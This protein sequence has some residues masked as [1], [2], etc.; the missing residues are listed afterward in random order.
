M[1]ASIQVELIKLKRSKIMLVMLAG[2]ALVALLFFSL[3]A[4]GA[5]LR[6]WP[7]YFFAGLTAWATFM[8]P[9]TATIIATLLAQLEHPNIAAIYG[10]EDSGDSPALVLEYVEGPTL[11]DRIGRDQSPI[12]LDEALPIANQIADAVAA[13]VLAD[14]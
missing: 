7:L 8:L 12:P 1:L 3:Q 13:S 14:T 5:N 10:L 11:Q 2:P 4:S 9:L 6:A